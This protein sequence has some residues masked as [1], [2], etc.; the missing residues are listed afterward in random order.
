MAGNFQ[1]LSIS[2]IIPTYNRD[3]S[4]RDCLWSLF[5]QV[6]QNY[7]IIVV[8][9]SDIQLPEKERFYQKYEQRFYLRRLK[10]PSIPKAINLGI[11]LARGEIILLVDDDIL[12]NKQLLASHVENYEDKNLAGVIGRVVTKG[13][14]E[15]PDFQSVGRITSWGSV[16]GGYSSKIRQE[17]GNV[18]G[19]NV[20]FRK[21]ILKKVGGIDENFVGN[22]LRWETDLA[23]RIRREGGKIIFDPKAEI[24]HQRAETG[25]C[26][27]DNRQQWFK[28]FFQ[29]EAYFCF[30][31]IKWYWWPIFWLNRWQWFLRSKSIIIPW[32]GICQGG[33]AFRRFKN[34]NRG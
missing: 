19:C 3:Q 29:N 8:D 30:K 14:E 10:K 20:S 9:Q 11:K 21:E 5:Q 26:R 1:R 32:Q 27:M 22:S 23:L 24:I 13:Q 28:D 6:Y 15:E 31:W 12:A 34:E 33:Q 2:I 25:G 16:A 18:I 7:E 17:V 4:L